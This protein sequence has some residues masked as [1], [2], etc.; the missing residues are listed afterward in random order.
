MEFFEI[1]CRSC[2]NQSDEL[3]SITNLVDA[4]D[5]SEK[6]TVADVIRE[7]VDMKVKF[8]PNIWQIKSMK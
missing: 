4:L 8:K 2:A 3:I 7:C 1:V 6:K 5:N